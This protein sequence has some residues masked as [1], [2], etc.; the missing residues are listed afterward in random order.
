MNLI[1]KGI[2]TLA[3][4]ILIIV[5]LIFAYFLTIWAWGLIE[6]LIIMPIQAGAPHEATP[7]VIAVVFVVAALWTLF[8]YLYKE[9]LRIE[10]ERRKRRNY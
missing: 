8:R 3:N 9:R 4:A 6:K 5:G 7:I 2:D 1:L 10:E